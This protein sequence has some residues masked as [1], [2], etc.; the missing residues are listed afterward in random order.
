M[1]GSKPQ[2]KGCKWIIGMK[3]TRKEI[4]SLLTHM[5][6]EELNVGKSCSFPTLFPIFFIVNDE[7]FSID[8]FVFS[9]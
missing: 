4:M 8:V 1:K 2:E 6:K 3:V 7:H 9:K 5:Y